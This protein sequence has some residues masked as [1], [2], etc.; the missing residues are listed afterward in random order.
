M[1]HQSGIKNSRQSGRAKAHR[2]SRGVLGAGAAAGAFLAFGMTPLAT[3][4]QAQADELDWITDL[5]D[6]SSWFGAGSV[7][8]SAG[9]DLGNWFDPSAAGSDLS[10]GADPGSLAAV[11]PSVYD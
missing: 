10:A 6:P 2:H 1:T 11:D 9:V 5:F 7:D 4:P 8:P 3:A